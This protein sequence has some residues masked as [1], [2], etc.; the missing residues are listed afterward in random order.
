MK[1]DGEFQIP[2]EITEQ[3]HSESSEATH[4]MSLARLR[5]ASFVAPGISFGDFSFV[6]RTSFL[7]EFSERD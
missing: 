6:A 3:F 4:E 7:V 1:D 2:E 5:Q